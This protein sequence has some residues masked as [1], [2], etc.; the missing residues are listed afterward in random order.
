MTH[1]SICPQAYDEWGIF[2]PTWL[3]KSICKLPA[4]QVIEETVNKDT[5]TSGGTKDFCLKPGAV[6]K[7][8]SM[9]ETDSRNDKN[10]LQ[11]QPCRSA[12]TLN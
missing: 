8:D 1:P 7:Q 10:H 6:L 4:D 3:R 12:N 2:S 5:H 9:L 11:V